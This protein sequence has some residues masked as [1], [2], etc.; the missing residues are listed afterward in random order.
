MSVPPRH[1]FPSNPYD[2]ALCFAAFGILSV[3]VYEIARWC[4][5]YL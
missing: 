4:V 1:P 2:L 3:A 5:R